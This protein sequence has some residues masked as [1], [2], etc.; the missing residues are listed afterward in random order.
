MTFSIVAQDPGKR[1]DRPAHSGGRAACVALGQNAVTEVGN[2]DV[3]W[4]PSTE[5]R[6]GPSFIERGESDK[7]VA[8]TPCAATTKINKIRIV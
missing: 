8:G 2:T 7:T 5:S 1:G 4:C 3:N 6:I